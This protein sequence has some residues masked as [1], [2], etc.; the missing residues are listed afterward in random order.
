M[1]EQPTKRKRVTVDIGQTMKSTTVLDS[2][3]LPQ[4]KSLSAFESVFKE[5]GATQKILQQHSLNAFKQHEQ[6][7]SNA[8]NAFKQQ[9]SMVGEAFKALKTNRA[10]ISG[11]SE[12]AKVGV[13]AEHWKKSFSLPE[14][15]SESINAFR[16]MDSIFD[17][18][19]SSNLTA[20]ANL[21]KPIIN[22]TTEELVLSRYCLEVFAED[23]PE[24]EPIPV[25]PPSENLLQSYD[26]DLW[27]MYTGAYDAFTAKQSDYKRH[28]LTSLRELC[29]HLLHSLAPNENVAPWIKE[30]PDSE[31]LLHDGSPT[32]R[33]RYLYICR[34]FDSE[35]IGEFATQDARALRT[36]FETL[37]RLHQ[38]AP[39]IS[40]REL[41]VLFMRTR[42]F[43]EYTLTLTKMS[44]N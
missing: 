24:P 38:K 39:S 23:F 36:L 22:S 43:V 26:Q 3:V 44:W 10:I 18:A 37:N 17:N 1:P 29:S 20:F 42:H 33:A 30:H 2:L 40:D 35:F 25:A 7:F 15:F 9:E 21:P 5:I 11:L 13:M 28:V 27:I 8:Q 31:T 12:I 6:L 34:Y 32:R 16:K 4:L 41:D 19:I 14:G